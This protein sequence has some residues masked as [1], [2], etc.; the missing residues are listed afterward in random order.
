MNSLTDYLMAEGQKKTADRWCSIGGC[1]TRWFLLWSGAHYT[2]QNALLKWFL[3]IHNWERVKKEK[4]KKEKGKEKKKNKIKR[5][6]GK[7][8]KT[9][10]V[11]ASATICNLLS[12]EHTQSSLMIRLLARRSLTHAYRPVVRCNWSRRAVTTNLRVR[13]LDGIS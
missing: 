12:F 2:T 9:K 11:E 8:M 3:I 10:F 7:W 1:F 5:I 13:E 4:K 6:W